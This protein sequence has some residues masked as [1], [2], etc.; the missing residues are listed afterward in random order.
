M[1]FLRR[2]YQAKRRKDRPIER[3]G[4]LTDHLKQTVKQAM[5]TCPEVA[6]RLD[7][8]APVSFDVRVTRSAAD[9]LEIWVPEENFRSRNHQ[10]RVMKKCAGVVLA[11]MH[12]AGP[13]VRDV[14]FDLSDGDHA[15]LAQ[16]RFSSFDK[17]VLLVPDPYFFRERGYLDIRALQA[18][19]DVPWEERSAEFV[20][21]GQP[22]GVGIFSCDPKDRDN[23][24][25]RQR[26]RLAL[27]A[28][29]T[30]LD[31][32]FVTAE[33]QTEQTLLKKEGFF[34]E[35]I[36]VATWAGRKYAIDVDGHSNAWDNLYHRLILG[37]CV[38]KIDSQ[39]GF[40]QW[41][42]DRLRPY[43]HYVPV[44]KDLSDLQAQMNWV[45][46]HDAEAK[47]IAAA[48]QALVLSMTFETELE[49]TAARLRALTGVG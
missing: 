37:T 29:G 38:L 42:Y 19:N 24:L 31:F 21:R 20:W 16:C 9:D 27:H 10:Y 7:P 22:T 47:A 45:R 41:Y 18:R 15:S 6:V 43:E 36:G 13:S 26:L 11:Y 44:K 34:A 33:T 3:L 8:Q 17:D 2:S 30:D 5:G 1:W 4:K 14:T 12:A 25:V 46:A 23:A 28:R 32:R 35:R 49:A 48:G 39:M 40:R